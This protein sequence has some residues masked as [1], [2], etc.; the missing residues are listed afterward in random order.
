M[1]LAPLSHFRTDCGPQVKKFAH[2]WSSPTGSSG[3]ERQSPGHSW[4]PSEG[5]PTPDWGLI[6]QSVFWVPLGRTGTCCQPRTVWDRTVGRPQRW[7]SQTDLR[8]GEVFKGEYFPVQ[9]LQPVGTWEWTHLQPIRWLEGAD[10][11]CTGGQRYRE[12]SFVDFV[13]PSPLFPAPFY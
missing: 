5:G 9:V 6:K 10:I 8:L 4:G 11:L 1:L 12:E 2:P 3:L 7:T 13:H